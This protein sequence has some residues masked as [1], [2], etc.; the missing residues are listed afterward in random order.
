MKGR[1]YFKTCNNI[2]AWVQETCIKESAV[3][4]HIQWYAIGGISP[5]IRSKHSVRLIM[6]FTGMVVNCA[7]RA[8]VHH[9]K[10]II[11]TNYIYLDA[12]IS[13][14]GQSL[15]HTQLFSKCM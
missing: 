11:C 13:V 9:R 6:K 12:I 10:H 7:C 1:L 3:K 5:C 15:F 8:N 4:I 2:S 14:A